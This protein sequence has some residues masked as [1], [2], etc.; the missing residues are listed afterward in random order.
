MCSR[1]MVGRE[2]MVGSN[3]EVID[4]SEIYKAF[5]GEYFVSEEHLLYLVKLWLGEENVCCHLEEKG[6][7]VFPIGNLRRKYMLE[8]EKL[9]K[10]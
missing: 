1:Q 10:A 4:V 2:G 7:S 5:V 9:L 3:T 6:L 8:I